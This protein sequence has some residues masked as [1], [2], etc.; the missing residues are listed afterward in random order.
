MKVNCSDD[1]CMNK[2]KSECNHEP[3]GNR[4]VFEMHILLDGVFLVTQVPSTY[5]LPANTPVVILAYMI[6]AWSY[7]K[8][9]MST[10]SSF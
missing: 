5:K 6:I 10:K 7:T 2:S 8:E 3:M 1:P 9:G 4:L